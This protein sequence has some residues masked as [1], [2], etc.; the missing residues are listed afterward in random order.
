MCAIL[1]WCGELPPGLLANLLVEMQSR[2]RDSTGISWVTDTGKRM[3]LK[4]DVPANVFVENQAKHLA[5]IEKN[6]SGIAHTRRASKGMPVNVQNAHPFA[7]CGYVFAHNGIVQNWRSIRENYIATYVDES[8]KYAKSIQT[9]S[10]VL[11]P[12][13]RNKDFSEAVGSM[14]LVWI[15]PDGKTWA[16]RSCKELESVM[17]E[18]E[19]TDS[20][21][22]HKVSI[23]CSTV[24]IVYNAI[25][26]THKSTG[27]G[28]DANG[29]SM[30]EHVLYRNTEEGILDC[31]DVPVNEKNKEDN[32]T[33]GKVV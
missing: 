10:L 30:D 26:A 11:G 18:W 2:G 20:T 21:V 22:K 5:V 14:G 33:S 9:D 29:T 7:Y 32:F 1:N 16:M 27:I 8:L 13:I 3:L 12:M 19:S 6:R 15:S 23:V 31:G 24:D 4:H 17:I 28:Y 25:E